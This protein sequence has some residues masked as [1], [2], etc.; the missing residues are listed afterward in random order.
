MGTVLKS[1]SDQKSKE[2]G[3]EEKVAQPPEKGIRLDIENALSFLDSDASEKAASPKAAFPPP[4]EPESLMPEI[5]APPPKPQKGSGTVPAARKDGSPP[6]ND[7]RSL[8]S[9]TTAKKAVPKAKKGVNIWI[10]LLGAAI[11]A[12]LAVLFLL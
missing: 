7:I 12:L 9:Q 6:P 2:I 4:E 5:E 11:L 10:L 3:K 1:V 8:P